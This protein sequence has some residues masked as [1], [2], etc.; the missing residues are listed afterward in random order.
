ME[1]AE[2]KRLLACYGIPVNRTEVAGSMD[3]ALRLAG[4]MGLSL[5]S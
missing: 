2:S 3:K 4:D 1:E 5:S